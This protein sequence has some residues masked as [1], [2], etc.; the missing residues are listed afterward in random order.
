M[1]LKKENNKSIFLI[2]AAAILVCAGFQLGFESLPS[3][4]EA[5]VSGAA[6]LVL[7]AVLLMLSNLIGHNIKHKLVFTRLSNEMP[8][9]RC[10]TLCKQD[11]RIDISLAKDKWPDVFS[12]KTSASDRNSHWYRSIYK[13][14]KDTPEVLQAHGNFL[15]YRDVFSSLIG[16]GLV[17][18]AWSLWG[19]VDLFGPIKT[20]VYVVLGVFALVSMIAARNAGNRFVVNAVAAAI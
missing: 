10:D 5:G 11:P 16:V 2:V 1:D 7:S 17:V 20:S 19:P 12:E 14:V 13:G 3:G 8:G 15:L 4:V 6:S 18:L 9:S